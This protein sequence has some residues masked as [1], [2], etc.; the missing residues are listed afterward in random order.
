MQ[1]LP[2]Q[3]APFI[4]LTM[5]GQ[6]QATISEYI[7]WITLPTTAT[8]CTTHEVSNVRF[9]KPCNVGIPRLV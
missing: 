4:K 2:I 6:A 9:A 7:A 8:F 1:V 5:F 3:C